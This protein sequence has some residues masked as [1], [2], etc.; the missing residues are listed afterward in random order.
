MSAFYLRLFLGR[1][2]KRNRI[3]SFEQE[4]FNFFAEVVSSV[5]RLE[6]IEAAFNHPE[7]P[8]PD[9]DLELD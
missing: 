6:D 8:V 7:L 3:G 2:S 1:R 4:Y 9:I 5:F